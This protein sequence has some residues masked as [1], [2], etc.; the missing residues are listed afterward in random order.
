MT[1]VKEMSEEGRQHDNGIWSRITHPVCF[2]PENGHSR[3]MDH[4]M[5]QKWASKPHRRVLGSL[6]VRLTI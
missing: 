3:P 6:G 5:M 2:R 4:F 1:A